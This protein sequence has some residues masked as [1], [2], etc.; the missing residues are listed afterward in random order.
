MVPRR[1]SWSLSTKRIQLAVAYDG[2]DFYGW[3]VQSGR[4]TVQ[5]TL[6]EAVHRV[7]GEDCEIIGASR[8]DSGA[9]ARGQV[10]HFDTNSGV[11]AARYER[12]LNRLLEGDVRI[13][14]SKEVDSTFHS[15]FCAEDRWYRYRIRTGK[16][17]PFESR[18][19]FDY[20][21]ALNRSKMEKAAQSLVG[22]HDFRSFT[23]ELD[24]NVEN[25]IRELRSIVLTEQEDEIWIDIVGTAFLRGMMRRI[26]GFLLEVG[27]G[28]R[29]V[30][31]G[32]ALLDQKPLQGPVVLPAKGLCLMEVRYLDPPRDNRS[33]ASTLA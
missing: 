30:E 23:E 29:P 24:P 32:R 4:R 10:C 5:G 15:R 12:V 16:S 14:K 1:L 6:K 31:D 27:R 18:W 17:D 11:P 7:T 25:T 3:A 26:S 22:V 28:H 20:G 13:L 21:R 8:T 19:A 9:H 33:T 2:T